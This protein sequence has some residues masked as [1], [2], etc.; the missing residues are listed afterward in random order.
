[1]TQKFEMVFNLAAGALVV[2]AYNNNNTNLH[3]TYTEYCLSI[4]ELACV[5]LLCIFEL[6]LIVSG[7]TINYRYTIV[8][9]CVQAYSI[10]FSSFTI[11]NYNYDIVIDSNYYNMA[12]GII[13]VSAFMFCFSCVSSENMKTDE[14]DPP[15]AFSS[16]MREW[17]L[18]M[19]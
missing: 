9:L 18:T 15:R 1:M 10:A 19:T 3:I 4:T 16:K 13:S 7:L 5:V 11:R 14:R 2:S 12:I 17:R 8:C 6:I